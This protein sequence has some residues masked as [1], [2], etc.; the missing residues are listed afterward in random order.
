MQRQ[1]IPGPCQQTLKKN[2]F[3]TSPS[4]VEGDGI[5]SRLFSTLHPLLILN[6]QSCTPNIESRQ[7]KSCYY[8][9]C[10]RCK[11]VE[12]LSDL[13]FC[14]VKDLNLTLATRPEHMVS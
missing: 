11:I 9:Q 6:N 2:F 12:V 1:N 4:N 7:P 13:E 14:I 8:A 3:L 10:C 5:K